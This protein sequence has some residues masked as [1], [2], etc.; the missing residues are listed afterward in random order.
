MYTHICIH[1]RWKRCPFA[2]DS[3]SDIQDRICA[4]I[5]FY[6]LPSSDKIIL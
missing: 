5:E 4:C 2:R 3:D 1:V 6:L